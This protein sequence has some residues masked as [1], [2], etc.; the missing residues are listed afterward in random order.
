MPQL[1]REPVLTS[2]ALAVP[3]FTRTDRGEAVSS[4]SPSAEYMSRTPLASAM[5]TMSPEL[6]SARA[7]WTPTEQGRWGRRMRA[8][9]NPGSLLIPHTMVQAHLLGTAHR[10]CS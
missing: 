1:G 5:R 7:T 9:V 3:L 2:E 6:I 4:A 8:L 10:H